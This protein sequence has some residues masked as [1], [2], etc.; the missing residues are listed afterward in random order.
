[1]YMFYNI[2]LHLERK[3]SPDKKSREHNPP[4]PQVGFKSYLPS[5]P[6]RLG[7]SGTSLCSRVLYHRKS[8]LSIGFWKKIC[9]LK[10]RG[11]PGADRASIR[12]D[13]RRSRSAFFKKRKHNLSFSLRTGYHK[14]DISQKTYTVVQ[15]KRSISADPIPHSGLYYTLFLRVCK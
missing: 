10:K 12:G 2:C 1:M 8:D 4:T 13:S 7:G 5:A 11:N 14:I 3:K 15:D 6:L 9:F